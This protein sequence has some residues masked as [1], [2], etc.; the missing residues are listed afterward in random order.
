MFCFAFILEM[1]VSARRWKEG[2]EGHRED[3]LVNS[4][5]LGLEMICGNSSSSVIK[6]KKDPLLILNLHFW[7]IYV[8]NSFE[9]NAV[10]SLFCSFGRMKGANARLPCTQLWLRLQPV[11][12]TLCASR[13]THSVKLSSYFLQWN[14]VLKTATQIAKNAF[15]YLREV[16]VCLLIISFIFGVGMK[17]LD[18]SYFLNFMEI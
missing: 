5:C 16:F 3:E 8:I 13:H 2:R 14:S 1:T 6:R 12:Y 10:R 18:G 4:P 17:M 15:S 11:Q 7:K 9:S